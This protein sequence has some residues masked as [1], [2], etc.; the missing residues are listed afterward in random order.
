[1]PARVQTVVT[2][3][4]DAV[5]LAIENLRASAPDALPLLRRELQRPTATPSEQL[6]A[7]CAL[8]AFDE[9]ALETIATTGAQVPLSVGECKNIV[10]A[11]QAAANRSAGSQIRDLLQSRTAHGEAPEQRVRW[12]TI[13]LFFGD[14]DAAEQVLLPAEDPVCR[15][16]LIHNFANWRGD[17]APLCSRLRTAGSGP[18]QSC[19]CLAI[20]LLQPESLTPAERQVA[21]EMLTAQYQSA[22][23]APTH[24]AAGWALRSWGLPLPPLTASAAPGRESAGRGWFRSSMGLSMV[25]IEPGSFV[26]GDPDANL[27]PDRL[28]HGVTITQ[29]YFLADREISRDL[30]EA[31][32]TDPA[33][34]ESEKPSP[35]RPLPDAD[36]SPTGAHPVQFV[37]WREAA[38]FCNWLSRREGCRPCYTR[39]QDRP[40]SGDTSGPASEIEASEIA[41][42]QVD[43]SEIDA[44]AI[45]TSE[46]WRWD[47]SADGYRLPTEAEWEFA[48][49][50]G[51]TTTFSFGNDVTLLPRYATVS[52]LRLVPTRPCGSLL[53]NAWGLF[54]MY[55]NV[56]EWCWDWFAPFESPPDVDPS[57][58]DEPLEGAGQRVVR[59]G[60]VVTPSGDPDSAARS[61]IDPETAAFRNLGFRVARN[62]EP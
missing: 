37:T 47:R 52:G 14:L 12:A 57:G 54:D 6:H 38:L 48:C 51:T 13:A 24:G 26:M 23:D 8:A 25:R 58:P 56:W 29:P 53:P 20:G 39:A 50:A 31:F 44:S 5:P 55:G 59:G 34:P 1:M 43:G 9:V 19:V 36:V 21:T 22:N 16:L 49:R 33:Y 61:G 4:P 60:G 18:L 45:T 17:L 41:A 10:A 42:S 40:D 30:F 32:L 3:A 15:T 28:Q 46:V 7:A 62:A 11:L 35:Q 27:F 2:A